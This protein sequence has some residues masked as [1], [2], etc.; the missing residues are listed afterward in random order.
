MAVVPATV[1]V[2]AV[3]WVSDVLFVKSR[4]ERLCENH[5]DV[6]T[7]SVP[8]RAGVTLASETM[9]VCSTSSN[10]FHFA[11]IREYTQFLEKSP[12]GDEHHHHH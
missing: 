2:C 10:A 5:G 6:W 11:D 9:A 3:I 8:M 7:Q 12:D 1:V 4:F